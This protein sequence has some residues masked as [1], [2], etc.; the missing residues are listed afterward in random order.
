MSCIR[1]L[2]RLVGTTGGLSLLVNAE[3]YHYMKSYRLSAGL[4]VLV[5]DHDDEHVLVSNGATSADTGS[6]TTLAIHRKRV[7]E[8]LR[9]G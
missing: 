2:L 4:H 5:S 9:R 7:K 6:H 8:K 3:Q 1:T